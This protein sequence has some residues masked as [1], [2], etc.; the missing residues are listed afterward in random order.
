MLARGNL[1]YNPPIQRMKFIL[2]GKDVG[3]DNPF[4]SQN[5]NRSIVARGF[6]AQDV[7]HVGIAR[8][9]SQASS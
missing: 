4:I 2:R 8:I 9:I 7:F 3:E 5:T 1:W 6:Y